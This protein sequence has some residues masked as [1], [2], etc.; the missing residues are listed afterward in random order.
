MS[1]G[2]TIAD[3]LL[4]AEYMPEEEIKDQVVVL[5]PFGG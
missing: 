5:L 4:L 1:I 3:I 2:S